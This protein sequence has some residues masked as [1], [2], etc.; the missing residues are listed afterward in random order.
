MGIKRLSRNA[1]LTANI[2]AIVLMLAVGY[3]DRINPAEHA[4]LAVAGLAFPVLL[5]VNVGFLLFWLVTKPR[6]VI[7]PFIGFLICYEPVREYTPVNIRRDVPEKSI[8][9]LSYNVWMFAGWDDGD[10]TKNPILDYIVAQNADIACLQEASAAEVGLEKIKKTLDAHYRYHDMEYP[11]SAKKGTCVAVYTRYP[12]V[13]KERIRYKSTGNMSMAYWL[14]IDGERVLLVNNHLETT[15]FSPEQKE[16]FHQLVKGEMETDTA[17]ATSKWLVV[18]LAEGMRKRAPEADAVARYV[19]RKGKGHPVILCGDFNDS[20]ISYAHHT[21]AS[22]LTDCYI[23]TG[24]GPGI[25]YHRMGFF[26]RIDN[27]MCSEHFEPYGC[28]I[29]RSISNSDHYPI[30]CWLKRRGK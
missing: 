17:E 24:N 16:K 29:D 1:I 8:K 5:A 27:I 25:S 3:S 11:D 10:S 28:R 12:I 30:M 2:V 22:Q 20:P 21:I 18:K 23:A 26:V 15:G 4:T 6:L 14:D 19:A 13:G 9:V 7:V